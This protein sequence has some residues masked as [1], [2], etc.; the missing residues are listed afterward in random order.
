MV[1][2]R[3]PVLS[4]PLVVLIP[5]QPPEAVQLVASVEDQVRVAAVPVATD[6]G[7][8]VRVI[9]GTGVG[10]PSPPPPPPQAARTTVSKATAAGRNNTLSGCH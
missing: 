5:F 8:A 9:A 2:A 10:S 7:L 1:A 6:A 3:A 4:L